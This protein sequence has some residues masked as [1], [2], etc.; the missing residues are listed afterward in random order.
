MFINWLRKKYSFYLYL[1]I[2]PQLA[3]ASELWLQLF[4]PIH[5]QRYTHLLEAQY[6]V[7][8]HHKNLS[9]LARYH[10][11]K[12]DK[13]IKW[14][15][16][17]MYLDQKMKVNEF[18]THLG[19]FFYSRYSNH[20]LMLEQRMIEK[21]SMEQR[22]RFRSEL[23]LKLIVNSFFIFNEFFIQENQGNTENRWGF[24]YNQ[25]VGKQYFNISYNYIDLK[26]H[27]NKHMLLVNYNF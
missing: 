4:K 7:D 20:R 14:I 3:F 12:Q 13:H 24:G 10:L 18:R 22:F 2:I 16:G 17:L 8:Q 25:K 27:P 5:T 15:F 19:F 1:L 21:T 26:N 9:N 11:L 6:R 23:P